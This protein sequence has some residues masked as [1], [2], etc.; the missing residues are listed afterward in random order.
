MMN[1]L[2]N[3]IVDVCTSDHILFYLDLHVL[4]HVAADS[5]NNV[6]LWGF[7]SRLVSNN[8]FCSRY[9][10]SFQDSS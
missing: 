1:F 9:L 5:K 2:K 10:N 6:L 4:V 8:E 3:F 7:F